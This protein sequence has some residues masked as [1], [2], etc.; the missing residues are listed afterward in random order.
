MNKQ[1]PLHFS[2]A[3]GFPAGSYRKFLRAFE[4]D[5]DIGCIDKLGHD[6][7]FPVTDGWPHL[8]TQT[9]EFIEQRY[10]QPVIGLGH[11]LGGFLSFLAAIKRPDLFR[12]VVM[13]DAPVF[14]K[15][16]ST[17][18]WL[19]KR[20]GI[21]DRITP[22]H[23]TLTRRSA[24][25]NRKETLAHFQAKRNFSTFDPDC[26][27]DYVDSVTRETTDGVALSFEPVVEHAIYC[28]LPDYFPQLRGQL[29]TPAAF[30]GAT[31]STYVRSADIEHM[32]RH[33]GMK[34]S[35]FEGGHLFP[36]EK[37]EAAAIAVRATIDDLLG[38]NGKVHC[39]D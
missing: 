14:S 9:I 21:I 17:M 3:N 25:A 13:L 16:V 29:K 36:L 32:K 7:R 18:L 33:F 27:R 10:D 19:S 8:I 12:A 23:G 15:R 24:W 2:H 37:P 26:L 38:A 35:M 31:G 6:P 4:A 28:G 39:P 22:G 5:F 20:I 34:V 1:L 11:S 30:I